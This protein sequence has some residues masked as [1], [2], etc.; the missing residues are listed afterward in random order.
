MTLY[1]GIELAL[2]LT[3]VYLFF[4][5]I[6]PDQT[7]YFGHFRLHCLLKTWLIVYHDCSFPI[8]LI[9]RGVTAL[10]DLRN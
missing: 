9:S 5:Q 1:S 4:N 3:L 2:I 7:R 10:P 8:R 6:F